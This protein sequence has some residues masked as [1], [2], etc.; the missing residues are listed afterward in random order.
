M[1]EEKDLERGMDMILDKADQGIHKARG[2]SLDAL[3]ICT[4]IVSAARA[5]GIIIIH[6]KERP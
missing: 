3:L 4:T 5:L 1:S 2:V 6:K